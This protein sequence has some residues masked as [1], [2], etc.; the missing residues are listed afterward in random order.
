ME[1]FCPK[2]QKKYLVAESFAGKQARCKNQ[3]CGQVF[4]VTARAPS[5][6]KPVPA[7]AKPAPAARGPAM[8]SLLDEL[9]PMS[10]D[11]FPPA[12]VPSAVATNYRPSRPKGSHKRSNSFV[13]LLAGAVGAVVIV[14]CVLALILSNRGVGGSSASAGSGASSAGPTVWSPLDYVPENAQ[15]VAYVDLEDLRKSDL[16]P[17]IRKLVSEHAPQVPPDF[18]FDIV[19]EVF[20]AGCGF[21]P[22]DEPQIVLRTNS[23][24]PLKD[25]LPKDRP[26]E[27]K[28]FQYV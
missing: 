21:G 7:P 8:S 18:D 17:D 24:H 16:Y 15:W 28:K 6:P 3:S 2:C 12:G 23:D 5:A 25:L 20:V 27:M 19:G 9:P 10:V 1:I 14:G 26:V 4:T 13:L 22:N 11:N